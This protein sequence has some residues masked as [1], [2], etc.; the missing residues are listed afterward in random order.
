LNSS[1][2][3]NRRFT[4]KELEDH[5]WFPAVFRNFQ[6]EFIGFV[7]AKFN[8][9]AGFIKYLK[10]LSLPSQPMQDLCSGSGEPAISIFKKSDC[11]TRLNLGDKF[12]N[13]LTAPNEKIFYE[14][15]SEDVLNME[16]KP[17][18]CYTMFNA[19][20]HFTDEDKLTIIKKI[21][22]SG[23]SAFIVEILE[24]RAVCLL[25]VLFTTVAGSLLITPL[26]KPFSLKRL[27][28]T[29]II[30]VNVI[31]ITFDGIISVIRSR[32]HIQYQN[33]FSGMSDTVKVLTLKRGMVKLNVIQ[34][35]N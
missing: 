18:T 23:S 25:R 11:F 10:S 12:P 1:A 9:Y 3:L 34:L 21:Q 14:T 26:I 2:Y 13:Q 5:N 27:F 32:S 19:F 31:A 6:T 8:L 4:L 17:G 15:K 24:P 29:Y 28:F 7:V 16:Y 33:L 22:A 20:H 30:P 35:L